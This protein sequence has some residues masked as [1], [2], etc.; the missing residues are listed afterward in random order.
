ML[1]FPIWGPLANLL[2][3]KPFRHSRVSNALS[4]IVLLQ[5]RRAPVV[6][7]ISHYNITID[8]KKYV[9]INELFFPGFGKKTTTPRSLLRNPPSCIAQHSRCVSAWWTPSRI[10][11]ITWWSRSSN[12]RGTISSVKWERCRTLTRCWVFTKIFWTIACTTACWRHR[13]CC[14]QSPSCA[15]CASAFANLFR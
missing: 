3:S 1:C 7:V 4:S 8:W 15:T 2:G 13:L 5:T 14:D 12:R 9:Y 10:S 11:N 6:Q